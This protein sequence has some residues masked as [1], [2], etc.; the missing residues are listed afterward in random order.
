MLTNVVLF[1]SPPQYNTAMRIDSGVIPRGDVVTVLGVPV[2][3]TAEKSGEVVIEK[4]VERLQLVI[5]RLLDKDMPKQ[6][7]FTLLQKCVQFQLDYL[8]RM[9][10]PTVIATTAKRCDEILMTAAAAIMGVDT[11]RAGSLE[12]YQLNMARSQLWSP[13][14]TAASDCAQPMETG[15]SHSLPHTSVPFEMIQWHGRRSNAMHPASHS[16]LIREIR[17]CVVRIRS[18]IINCLPIDNGTDLHSFRAQQIV[19]LDAVLL[20]AQDLSFVSRT[21]VCTGSSRKQTNLD[22]L[23]TVMTHNWHTS[24]TSPLV[25]T[26]LHSSTLYRRLSSA[27]DIVPT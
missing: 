15:T 6:L 23:Q 8:L 17:E 4:R 9:A 11:T 19:K 16:K 7:A 18:D 20:P 2:G 1:S 24:N 3:K 21:S 5:K 14:Q 12:N 27:R 13:C 10:E 22:R 25:T 26:T